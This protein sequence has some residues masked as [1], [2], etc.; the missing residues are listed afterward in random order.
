MFLLLGLTIYLRSRVGSWFV[1][2]AFFGFFWFCL[3]AASLL[4]VDHRVP[5]LGT[6]VLVSLIAAV[7]LG[8]VL[9]ETDAQSAY[10]S[11][12]NSPELLHFTRV[13]AR[14]ACLLLT[15]V[16]MAGIV[17][18]IFLSVDFFNQSLSLESL[19]QMAAKWT[20]LRY[21]EF[22]DPW[23][24]RFAAVWIYP[25]ALLGGMLY[26]LSAG[27]ID[28]LLGAF[29]LV[30]SLLLTMLSGGRAAFLVGLVCWLGGFLAVHA[31]RIKARAR[32]WTLRSGLLLGSTALALL[33][34]FLGVNSLRGAVGA[35]EV[36]Q[37]SLD[38]NGGQVRNYIFGMPA[39][40]AEWFDHDDHSSSLAWGALTFPRLYDLL[41]IHPH[42]LGVYTD[43]ESTVGTEG[44]NIYTIFRGL[45]EDFTL[46][47]A[48]LFCGF[49]GFV[50]GRCY[51]RHSLQMR[52]LLA[53]SSYYAVAL[54]SPIICLYGFNG[55]IF[56]WIV[57]WLVLKRRNRKLLLAT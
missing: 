5:A 10:Q 51:S 7:Q 28:K 41:G 47:G 48:F 18:F 17:W 31:S 53:L 38:Y 57:A 44:T 55:P 52:P 42:T 27:R 9:A 23:P 43:S 25:P 12:S 33:L 30:P 29:S 39:A 35:S 1:P 8:S 26:P 22:E 37:L 54:Y 24:L 15:I 50:G 4:A 32:I 19:I 20:L 40:F 16:A 13:H 2:S 3:L 36:S 6:W 14:L 49:W 56:A 11:P 45:I 34:L 21:S 46:G